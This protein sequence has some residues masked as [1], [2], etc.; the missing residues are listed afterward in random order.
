MSRNSLPIN[1]ELNHRWRA[2]HGCF[3]GQIGPAAPGYSYIS[4]AERHWSR[5]VPVDTENHRSLLWLA[6]ISVAA[7]QSRTRPRR[8]RE[9]DLAQLRFL[10]MPGRANRASLL[11]AQKKYHRGDASP[12]HRVRHRCETRTQ[13]T[14]ASQTGDRCNL[15]AIPP[16]TSPATVSSI[17][18]LASDAT[19]PVLLAQHLLACLLQWLVLEAGPQQDKARSWCGL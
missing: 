4:W 18:I 12:R 15:V 14:T 8:W 9:D 13:K 6:G 2:A 11:R 17:R 10:Q 16:W 7:W 3:V 5:H 1:N 19:M